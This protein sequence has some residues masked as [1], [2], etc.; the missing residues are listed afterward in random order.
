[1]LRKFTILLTLLLSLPVLANSIPNMASG[2]LAGRVIDADTKEPLIGANVIVVGT[3]LGSATDV[4]GDYFILNV[5]PGTYSIK[6]SYIGYRD[7]T[8][9]NIRVYADLTSEVNFELRSSSIETQEIVVQAIRPLINKNSTNSNTL[10]KSE[11]IENLPVRGVN[12]I[13][14]QQAG[15]VN[16]GGNIYVRGSRSD[17][18]AFYVDGVLVTDALFG[19][20]SSSIITNSIEEIQF[21]AGGYSAE[22]GGATGGIVSTIT[23]SGTDRYNISLEA[24][25]DNFVSPTSDRKFLGGYS[26]GYSEYVATI[27]GPI[28]PN[29]K[30]FKFFLAGSNI[31]QRSPIRFWEG[32]NF[33]NLTDPSLGSRADTFSIVYPAGYIVNSATQSWRLQGNISADFKPFIFKV[34]G[35]YYQYYSRDGVGIGEL[36]AEKRA[37]ISEGYTATGNFKITHLLSSN[38]YY[39]LNFV[40]YSDYDVNMDPDFEHNIKSYGDSLDNAAIGYTLLRDGSD[41][42]RYRAFNSTFAKPSETQAFYQK[43]RQQSLGGNID[44]TYQIGKEHEFKTGGEFKY[45]TIRRYAFGS[46]NLLANYA[47]ENPDAPYTQ[48]YRRVDNYGYDLVGNQT[49]EEGLYRPKNPIFAAYYIQDKMEFNDLVFNLG[50]RLDYIKTDSKVFKD[51]TNIQFDE[52]GIVD[53]DELVEVDPTVQ[54][55]PRLGFSFNLT[56]VTKFHAQYGKFIQQTRLRDIY[57]GWVVASDNIKG[58]YAIQAPVGFGLKPERTTSYEIGFTQQVGEN[59]AFDITAFYKDIKDQVQIRFVYADPSS[60]HGSYYAFTNGDFAT[61]KGFELRL[62]LRRTE[63]LSAT[64]DY[65]FSDARGTGSTSSTGFRALWQSPT[66]TPFLP[67]Q[68]SPLDFNQTHRGSIN[69][70][71]RFGEDD[72]PAWLS[73]TGLNLLFTFNSGHNFTKV[74]GYGNG[75]IPLETLNEST[76]PWNFQIDAR[77]DKSFKLGPLDFNIYLWVINILNTKNVTDVFIQTGTTNNGYLT[78]DEGAG[79]VQSYRE[80]YGE[81]VAQK[82]IDVYNTVNNDNAN[83]YGTPRQIRLGLKLEY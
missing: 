69:A 23:K 27:S 52:E 82:Y 81:A 74:E 2:K 58:G 79:I 10:I 20:N 3:T 41:L 71:Y 7:F 70:D 47:R 55:S 77:L 73:N 25:T 34:G 56:D 14:S 61:T 60:Q 13:V 45:W 30:T 15:V 35:T 80:T 42:A 64:L 16:Q 12:S 75:R 63:R 76:T 17:A 53:P 37:G 50:F 32:A 36:L 57:Q 48:W 28:I 8:I 11:D 62:D 24:I 29:D 1:M 59:F 18:V 22:F 83:I 33:V 31:F 54:V 51:P 68:I 4:N 65:T 19:G 49:D 66:A 39:D 9:E 72:G 6:A 43:I 44:L 21:Q 26:Y 46:A 38:A 5:A 67:Q 40:Y 78:S